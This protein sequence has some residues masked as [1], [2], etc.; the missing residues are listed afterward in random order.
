MTSPEEEEWEIEI[1]ST[2]KII[3]VPK[4]VERP[5]KEPVPV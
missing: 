5:I 1:E 3:E 2:P 4:P